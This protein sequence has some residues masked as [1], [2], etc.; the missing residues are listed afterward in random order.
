M[1]P[2]HDTAADWPKQ[3]ADLVERC[4]R[5]IHDKVTVKVVKAVRFVVF[6]IIGAL[7]GL[8]AAVVFV[9]LL[10]RLCT[11]LFFGRVWLAHLLV[12]V[13]FLAVGS[14]CMRKRHR[15]STES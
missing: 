14:F 2:E 12:G 3:I 6:G 11:I 5:L 15:P 10:V 13:L 9:I 7:V 8:S 4:V 1:V